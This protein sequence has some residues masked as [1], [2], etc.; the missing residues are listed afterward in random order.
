MQTIIGATLI[1]A[2]VI[3]VI[4]SQIIELDSNV[5]IMALFVGSLTAAGGIA[6]VARAFR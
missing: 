4:G 5:S 1:I 6:L 3:V 2:G